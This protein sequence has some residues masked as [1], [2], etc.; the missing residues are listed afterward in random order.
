MTHP[1]GT[2]STV[3]ELYQALEPLVEGAAGRLAPAVRERERRHRTAR[4]IGYAATAVAVA[5]VLAGVAT[6]VASPARAPV[7]GPPNPAPS[8]ATPPAGWRLDSSLGIQMSVP[9]AWVLNDYGC[10]QDARPTVVRGQVAV[11]LCYTGRP[12]RKEF[13]VIS[14]ATVNP[15]TYIGDGAAKLPT[16]RVTVDGVPAVRA[17]GAITE[18]RYAGWIIVPSRDA[19]VYA[20]TNDEATLTRM[21]DSVRVVTVDFN[22]CPTRSPGTLPPRSGLSTFVDPHPAS[23]SV[24]DYA[25]MAPLEASAR[26]TGAD[27]QSLAAA[28]NGTLPGHVLTI[29]ECAPEVPAGY[30]AVLVVTSA[31]GTTRQVVVDGGSCGS[32]WMNNGDGQHKLEVPL[33]TRLMA[34][35]GGWG[36]STD[37]P[38]Q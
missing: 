2:G 35:T 14:G 8:V 6:L 30:D 26:H 4:R 24:C 37:A 38:G 28:L 25:R 32:R 9:A 12:P 34:G 19:Q 1:D 5:G 23:I 16:Q 13:V 7:A 36:Y 17:E 21:L 22:G 31:D 29:G 15:A 3:R 27:A 20:R 18:G 10:G 33:M 11:L